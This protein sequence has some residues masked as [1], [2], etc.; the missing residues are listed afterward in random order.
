MAKIYFKYGAMKSGKSM[1]CLRAIYNYQENGMEVVVAKPATDTRST[2]I[3]SR[4][5]A[6]V[7][8][9][10]IQPN[11]WQLQIIVAAIRKEREHNLDV[12][13]EYKNISAIIIDEAQFLTSKQVESLRGFAY[14]LDIPVICYGLSVD[15]FSHLFEGSKRLME[16][17]DDLQ[18]LIGICGCGRRAKQNA[19]KNPDGTFAKNG[20]TLEIGDAQYV[21]LCNKCYYEKVDKR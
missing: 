7:E 8:C 20:A 16:L 11:D 12:K 9:L 2:K 13:A 19:R 5:G 3:A 6:E 4:N 10:S 14:E 17:A 21:P 15:A 1:D 18:E